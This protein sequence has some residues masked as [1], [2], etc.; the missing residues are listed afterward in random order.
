MS[1]SQNSSY[2]GVTPTTMTDE[3]E[4]GQHRAAT[5]IVARIP[6]LEIISHLGSSFAC[7]FFLSLDRL[8]RQ[9]V[10]VTERMV[11]RAKEEYDPQPIGVE[12]ITRIVVS[13]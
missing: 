3:R 5:D 1:L 4:G 11:L 10:Y 8:P 2:R 6:T 13:G 9:I 7:T 12:R